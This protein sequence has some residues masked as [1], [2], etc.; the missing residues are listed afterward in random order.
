MKANQLNSKLY[1]TILY[2]ILRYVRYDRLQYTTLHYTTIDYAMILTLYYSILYDTIPY[3]ISWLNSQYVYRNSSANF[4]TQKHQHATGIDGKNAADKRKH[5]HTKRRLFTLLAPYARYIMH[6]DYYCFW[7]SRGVRTS[8]LNTFSSFGLFNSYQSTGAWIIRRDLHSKRGYFS[9]GRCMP[10][11]RLSCD[12]YVN[13][14]NMDAES[15][16]AFMN[17]K[18]CRPLHKANTNTMLREWGWQGSEGD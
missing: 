5:I 7:P 6:A 16:A 2:A 4:E 13:K 11:V 10:S 14:Y 15:K 9:A 12:I 18:W 17:N 1:C 8:R 3:H